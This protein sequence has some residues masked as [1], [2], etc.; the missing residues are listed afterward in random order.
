MEP[1]FTQLKHFKLEEF[2]CSSS[3]EARMDEQLLQALEEIR[4][5]LGEPMVITSGY[6]SDQ[7][8]ITQ[9]KIAKGA[10]HGGAHHLGYAADVG[11]A[12]PTAMK[13]L[14]LAI[15]NPTITGV[16]VKQSGPWNSRFIHIDAVPRDNNFGLTRPALWSY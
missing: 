14:A 13:I 2:A 10:K 4:E 9:A 8:P 3:G 6:R 5:R 12:G 11:C 15:E 16:G 1:D 7:H